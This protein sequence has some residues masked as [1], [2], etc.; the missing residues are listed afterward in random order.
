MSK[1]SIKSRTA[2]QALLNEEKSTHYVRVS[3]PGAF[4]NCD[5]DFFKAAGGYSDTSGCTLATGERTHGWYVIGEV[6][7][8]AMAESLREML[9]SLNALN[10]RDLGGLVNVVKM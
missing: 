5:M 3:L 1:P 2:K 8:N 10:K 6:K 4:T 9:I 7:A